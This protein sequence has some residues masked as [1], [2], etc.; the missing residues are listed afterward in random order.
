METYTSDQV[1]A[2]RNSVIELQDLA[3]VE[4]NLGNVVLLAHVIAILADH[5]QELQQAEA[6]HPQFIGLDLEN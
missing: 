4:D 5:I 3:M 6:K 1:I 2:V